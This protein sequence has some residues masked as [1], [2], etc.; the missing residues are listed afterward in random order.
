MEALNGVAVIGPVPMI[1]G[2]GYR[3]GY[4]IR[5]TIECRRAAQ[6]RDHLQETGVE[7]GDRR[8]FER[9]GRAAAVTGGSQDLVL[10]KVEQD[11]DARAVEYGRG[12][13]T[14]WGDIEGRMPR[15][16]QPRGMSKPVLAGDLQVEMQGGTGFAPAEVIE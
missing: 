13:Q 10:S 14:A 15:M 3:V 12:T 9:E 6:L 1:L 4:F 11:L 5:L 8:R 2:E 16:I 7:C